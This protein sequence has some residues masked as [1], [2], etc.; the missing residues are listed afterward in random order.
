M[1]FNTNPVYESLFSNRTTSTTTNR[2]H[3]P[4]VAA[5]PTRL[6]PKLRRGYA[7]RADRG[8][9]LLPVLRKAVYQTGQFATTCQEL[10]TGLDGESELVYRR[11]LG[12][13]D[14]CGAWGEGS[15]DMM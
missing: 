2:H 11:R 14:R 5:Q 9:A 4:D 1:L 8:N 7:N 15:H 13:H 10:H 3:A 12:W 6:D